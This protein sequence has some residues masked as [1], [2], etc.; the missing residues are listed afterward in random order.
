MGNNPGT[1]EVKN[2]L[3]GDDGKR[4]LMA[5]C[6]CRICK[7]TT[8]VHVTTPGAAH[9]TFAKKGWLLGRKGAATDKCPTCRN[10]G[11]RRVMS[12][13]QRIAAYNR[14]EDGLAGKVHRLAKEGYMTSSTLDATGATAAMAKLDIEEPINP[15]LK[16]KLEAAMQ[17]KLDA[18]KAV[19]PDADKGD[20]LVLTDPIPKLWPETLKGSGTKV[21]KT[22][23]HGWSSAARKSAKS[24]FAIQGV[25]DAV[26]GDHYIIERGR[27]GKYTWRPPTIER[28]MPL[29]KHRKPAADRNSN[30]GRAHR[31]AARVSAVRQL[32]K[33]GQLAIEGTTFE[34]YQETKGTF[35]WRPIG[36][37]QRLLTPEPAPTLETVTK[38]PQMQIITDAGPVPEDVTVRQPTREQRRAIADQLDHWYKMDEQR[39]RGSR[40][41]YAI[42]AELDLPRKW[43]TDLRQDLYG[44]HDRNDQ[45]DAKLKSL[46][47]G[48]EIAEAAVERLT[49]MAI[50]AEQLASQLKDL[51]AKLA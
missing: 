33:Q 20:D 48:I 6:K 8:W 47:V 16:V 23:G 27:D 42:A 44:D 40:S 30:G 50:E 39:Y 29:S 14:I 17:S 11:E 24:F 32:T 5:G 22:S 43:V 31:T 35:A 25:R 18:E 46:T 26:E 49:A 38:E 2:Q 1:F 9:V 36:K 34:V 41:D 45:T 12:Q 21:I 13:G 15:V 3:R 10:A 19:V 51:R 4:S 28:E 7:N 37:P